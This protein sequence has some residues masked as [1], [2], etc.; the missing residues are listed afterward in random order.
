MAAFSDSSFAKQFAVP[1][2]VVF[3]ALRNSAT[4]GMLLWFVQDDRA[5][6]HLAAYSEQGYELGAS[7][8]L[9]NDSIRH[10]TR[11]GLRWLSLG[12][13]AGVDSDGT[14]GLK[15]FKE[16]WSNSSRIAYFCGRIFD[17]R[18]YH[19]IVTSRNVPDT[20]YFPA[21]RLGEFQ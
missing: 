6:Y 15:R 20:K 1:G 16:G 7:F 21:Y 13:G 18:K 11:L 9:F 2:I 19:E 10:F 3:R 12:A 8:A 4:V 5:Y 14:S 17:R